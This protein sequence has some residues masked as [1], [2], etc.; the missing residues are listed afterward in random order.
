MRNFSKIYGRLL[1]N[2]WKILGKVMKN[3]EK[4]MENYKKLK[5]FRKMH[6][7]LCDNL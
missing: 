3:I 2:F 5:N 6:E 1:E 4:L 7:K